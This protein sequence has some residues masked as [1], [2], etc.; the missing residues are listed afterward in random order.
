LMKI[1]SDINPV[2]TF[3]RLNETDANGFLD[4]NI[5][6]LSVSTGIHADYHRISDTADKINYKGMVKIFNFMT[7]FLGML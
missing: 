3:E 1:Q 4:V 5:S 7:N 2:L 6:S